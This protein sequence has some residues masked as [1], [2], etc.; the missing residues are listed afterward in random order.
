MADP[1]VITA[2]IKKFADLQGQIKAHEQ[3]GER[4]KLDLTTI[5]AAIRV[6][7]ADADLSL[8]APKMPRNRNPWFRKGHCARA[9]IEVLKNAQAPM[10]AREIALHLLKERGV[11]DATA[12][13]IKFLTSTIYGVLARRKDGPV[14][15]HRDG[16]PKRWSLAKT[17]P[18]RLSMGD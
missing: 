7:R 14:T 16:F 2:L 1:H 13:S 8:V 10:S 6:F 4:I 11:T 3:E 12:R 9:A 15:L 17:S 5:E 18:Q